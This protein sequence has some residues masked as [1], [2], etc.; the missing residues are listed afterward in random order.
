MTSKKKEEY[1]VLPH[2]AYGLLKEGGFYLSLPF[3]GISLNEYKKFHHGQVSKLRGNY[4]SV[5][6]VILISCIKKTYIGEVDENGLRLIRPIFNSI[7]DVEWLLTWRNYNHHDPS[8]YTQKIF[9]DAI[10]DAGLIEDD[11]ELYV[12]RDITHFGKVFYDSITC[13]LLGDVYKVMF[14]NIIH[15][16]SY[17]KLM[18]VIK[19]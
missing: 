10:V 9:L 11:S 16:I 4:K 6:D 8:N 3:R 15:E 2:I 12:D 1:P 17:D 7:V 13:M 5:I 14:K 18:G 19:E